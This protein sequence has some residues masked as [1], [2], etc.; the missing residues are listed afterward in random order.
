[1]SKPFLGLKVSAHLVINLYPYTDARWR[2]RR[3]Q[4]GAHPHTWVLVNIRFTITSIVHLHVLCRRGRSTLWS[5]VQVRAEDSR[6]KRR[7]RRRSPPHRRSQDGRG[8]QRRS[9]PCQRPTCSM[10]WHKGHVLHSHL[11]GTEIFINLK[12]P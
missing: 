8:S 12:G 6:C 4:S 7:V 5:F 2:S 10:M 3:F 1:L 9:S 11:W